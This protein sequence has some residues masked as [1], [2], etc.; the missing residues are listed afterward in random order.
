MKGIRTDALSQKE[1]KRCP[2]CY[3]YSSP[4]AYWDSVYT[5]KRL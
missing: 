5:Q 3:D 2:K 1:D 4:N